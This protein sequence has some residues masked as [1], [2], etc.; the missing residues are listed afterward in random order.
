[1]SKVGKAN[2]GRTSWHLEC[3]GSRFSTGAAAQRFRSVGSSMAF[4]RSRLL[5]LLHRI[6]KTGKSS[7]PTF[8]A[9]VR[10]RM[11]TARG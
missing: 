3:T 11:C 9:A 4:D 7:T 6:S 1:M 10:T 8:E 5:R 2:V